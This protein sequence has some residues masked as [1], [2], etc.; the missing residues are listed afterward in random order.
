MSPGRGNIIDHPSWRPLPHVSHCHSG[1]RPAACTPLWQAPPS[2]AS[3]SFCVYRLSS[4]LLPGMGH[5]ALTSGSLFIR[6]QRESAV[7]YCNNRPK[8]NQLRRNMGCLGSQIWRFPSLTY[9]PIALAFLAT[10]YFMS[11]RGVGGGTFTSWPN[12]IGR[13]RKHRGFCYQDPR[14]STRYTLSRLLHQWGNGREGCLFKH[15]G[16]LEDNHDHNNYGSLC[17]R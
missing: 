17:T 6:N 11:G 15:M 8:M 13:K 16:L 9:G 7:C 5:W 14:P 3:E 4:S 10:Q 1:V 12:G 2:G